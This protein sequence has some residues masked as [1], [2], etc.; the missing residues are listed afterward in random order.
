LEI[1]TY[2]KMDKRS[3]FETAGAPTSPMRAGIVVDLAL[4]L[5]RQT[6]L[7]NPNGWHGGHV[8]MAHSIHVQR[9]PPP[10]QGQRQRMQ[11]TMNRESIL[12]A[13]D[14]NNTN[15]SVIDLTAAAVVAHGTAKHNAAVQLHTRLARDN[16]RAYQ[17]W[18]DEFAHWLPTRIIAAHHE[19]SNVTPFSRDLLQSD[20]TAYITHHELSVMGCVTDVFA[21]V[22]TQSGF[23]RPYVLSLTHSD[24]LVAL[25]HMQTINVRPMVISG[26]MY[27]TTLDAVHT[28]SGQRF[29]QSAIGGC[30]VMPYG[31]LQVACLFYKLIPEHAEQHAFKHN[32]AD[33]SQ[34]VQ[35]RA[36]SAF[37]I[38]KDHT[39][40]LGYVVHAT[41]CEVGQ[42]KREL[43]EYCK[44]HPGIYVAA[45]API[46]E[47][48]PNGQT[49]YHGAP[50]E[51]S[52]DTVA[53]AE[54]PSAI[55]VD[56]GLRCTPRVVDFRSTQ[57]VKAT[58]AGMAQTGSDPTSPSLS[59][60]ICGAKATR[61]V[62]LLCIKDDNTEL[63]KIEKE[64]VVY[65]TKPTS[66][67]TWGTRQSP[68]SIRAQ[69]APAFA[70]LA[71][72]WLDRNMVSAL[73]TSAN[74]AGGSRI[75]EVEPHVRAAIRQAACTPI[76]LTRIY[77]R[78]WAMAIDAAASQSGA[79]APYIPVTTYASAQP[80][81]HTRSY[82]DWAAGL[83][84]TV[85]A[86]APALYH[87]DSATSIAA[88]VL[89][90]LTIVAADRLSSS[91]TASWLWP[92]I[93]R[94]TVHTN[95]G[96]AG[97][98]NTPI[99]YSGVISTINWLACSTNTQVQAQEAQNLAIS[100]AYRKEKTTLLGLEANNAAEVIAL[101]NIHTA[102]QFLQPLTLWA[103]TT[104]QS[105]NG[106]FGLD[107]PNALLRDAVSSSLR[108]QYAIT[109]AAS[110]ATTP[111]WWGK[112]LSKHIRHDRQRLNQRS[113][114]AWRLLAVASELTHLMGIGHLPKVLHG[115]QPKAEQT[116][117][118]MANCSVINIMDIFDKNVAVPSCDPM[119]Y[120]M[121]KIRIEVPN[122]IVY[123]M[124]IRIASLA[125]MDTMA[126]AIDVL[127]QAGLT[128][129]YA[130][131]NKA[132]G[133]VTSTHTCPQTYKAGAQ[134]PTIQLKHHELV[135]YT[136][137][138]SI[139]QVLGAQ[140]LAGARA[141]ARWYIE[142]QQH[143]DDEPVN[144]LM[145]AGPSS[146]PG[147]GTLDAPPLSGEGEYD[148]ETP[149][150]EAQQGA[151]Q[152]TSMAPSAQ[153]EQE[154]GSLATLPSQPGIL[155]DNLLSTLAKEAQGTKGYSTPATRRH[156][157]D[158][159]QMNPKYASDGS[160]LDA[161]E[162]IVTD[163]ALVHP[164]HIDS[165]T[166]ARALGKIREQRR[167]NTMRSQ[168][169]NLEE[170]AQPATVI[171]A[172]IQEGVEIP[173]APKDTISASATASTTNSQTMDAATASAWPVMG[174][175]R[176]E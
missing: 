55:S 159:W 107:T 66:T 40:W 167:L 59:F 73:T 166:G 154:S 124:P 146:Q 157:I 36:S 9:V 99:H 24:E 88:E 170:Q 74:W 32:W 171:P 101:P 144:G 63:E 69:L 80:V 65:L 83:T 93:G 53:R 10:S 70:A 156:Q 76:E 118:M 94:L 6:T 160:Y 58:T 27:N 162:T 119:A 155:E 35:E 18:H 128:V 61:R 133:T 64:T 21:V 123:N 95:A 140:Q 60:S 82:T 77:V 151:I 30:A 173:H 116:P 22:G 67:I 142:T 147:W 48:L 56:T 5:P 141:A 14:P 136:I 153:P 12:Y 115:V 92:P 25:N 161:A 127:Q 134:V 122:E 103:T 49:L 125:P 120:K 112:A 68:T 139:Q 113:T 117:A 29:V 131:V 11:Y 13:R 110:F 7:T 132:M 90:V 57:A 165:A 109:T 52:D 121:S 174:I 87:D 169:K 149:P 72:S 31:N 130:A 102:G 96:Y 138:K 108:Y 54:D 51:T 8:P 45:I 145:P 84:G 47:I 78:L 168:S 137:A 26:Y 100:L 3:Q 16:Q 44:T 158:E 86:A 23:A 126:H 79:G 135:P 129:G 75:A 152:Q 2:K 17:D 81:R 91:P 15:L 1:K 175:T 98:V 71:G 46:K 4:R 105:D 28:T 172:D 106:S 33:D 19:Q 42:I 163:F 43:Y 85:S 34:P 111:S 164:R 97:G 50:Q 104:D 114:T 143:P 150:A 148:M 39:Q 20:H 38:R 62:R 37:G 41:R 89:P 176:L